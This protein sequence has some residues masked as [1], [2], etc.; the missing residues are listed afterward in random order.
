M[1]MKPIE[2]YE[3]KCSDNNGSKCDN[4]SI[5]AKQ[6]QKSENGKRDVIWRKRKWARVLSYFMINCHIE[7]NSSEHFG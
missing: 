7:E 1:L 6:G 4:K 3:G 2:D 5:K